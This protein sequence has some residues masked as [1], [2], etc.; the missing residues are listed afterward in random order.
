MRIGSY[1][2]RHFWHCLP[3]AAYLVFAATV[4]LNPI[5]HRSNCIFMHAMGLPCPFCGLTRAIGHLYRC[6]VYPAWHLNP[7]ALPFLLLALALMAYRAICVLKPRLVRVPLSWELAL[8]RGVFVMFVVVW[9]IRLN[10][11]NYA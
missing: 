11:K 10:L 5:D 1:R 7:M 6:E 9:V 4:P 8:Y 3:L 2:Q